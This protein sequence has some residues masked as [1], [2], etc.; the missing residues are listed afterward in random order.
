MHEMALTESLVEIAVEEARRQAA[1]RVLKI[2]LDVGALSHAEPEALA[3]CF[4]AVAV[5]TIAEGAA[6]LIERPA[7]V[8]WCEDCAKS[9]SLS[10]R[11]SACPEC[12]GYRVKMTAGDEFR[13]RELEIE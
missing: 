13:I 4:E 11:F 6:L 5:G 3:F 1:R 2:R 8:G 7:G 12:G 10:E 9:V